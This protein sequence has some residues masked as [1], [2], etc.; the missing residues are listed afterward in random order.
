LVDRLIV[1]DKHRFDRSVQLL[2]PANIWRALRLGWNLRMANY[3]AV[4]LFHHLST[5]Q[6]ALKY[7]AFCAATGA[8]RRLGL[9][10]GRGWFLTEKAPDEGY[11]VMHEVDYALRVAR[12]LAPEAQRHAPRL[13]PSPDDLRH[14]AELLAPLRGRCGPLIALHPGSGAYAPVRRWP[15]RR[16]AAVADRLIAAGARIV[17][18]GGAEEHDLRQSMLAQMQHPGAVL[19]LGGKTTLHQLVAVLGACTLFIGNDGGVMHLAVAAGTPVLAV[20]GPTDP[21]AWGPWSPEP[22]HATHSY[23]NGVDVLRSGPHTTLKAAIACS[24]CIYRGRGLGNP[25]GCPDVT[26]LQRI[27]VDQVL[28]TTFERLAELGADLSLSQSEAGMATA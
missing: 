7:A 2:H 10:N 13:E 11:G 4:L 20:Y 16:F 3:D 1:F 24:P 12:L 27:S 21:R 18:L 22:W 8:P 19:D 6:G 28:E 5:P 15:V 25:N 26:C 9:D 14:A 23:P 17:L